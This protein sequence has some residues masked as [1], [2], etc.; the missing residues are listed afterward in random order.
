VSDL[1]EAVRT[2][3]LRYL[4]QVVDVL[5]KGDRAVSLA[6][7][8]LGYNSSA[9]LTVGASVEALVRGVIEANYRFAETTRL[10]IRVDRLDIVEL[11]QDTAITAVYELR[12]APEKLDAL[13]KRTGTL[14][15]CRPDLEYGDGWRPRLFDRGNQ[16]YWPRIIVTDAD[17]QQGDCPPCPGDDAAPVPGADAGSGLRQAPNQRRTALANRLRYLYVGQR[18]RAES[19]VQQRQPGLIETLVRQQIHSAKWQEDFGRMLFQLMVPYDFKD[20]A[21]QLERVVLVVDAYTANLPWELMMGDGAGREEEKRPLSV[22][23]PVVRQLASAKF[24]RDVR[25]SLE[26]TALVIG[27]PSVE[28]FAAAF[29]DPKH[30]QAAV[31]ALP[32]AEKEA[33]AV[34]ALLGA[35]GYTVVT[36]IGEERMATDVLAMLYRQPYRILHIS[37]HGVFDLPHADGLR[38][39]GVVL[40][41]GLLITAAEIQAMEVVPELVFLSCCHLGQIDA[42][43]AERDD[44]TV[45]DG[46]KLAASVARELIEIGVRCVVVAGWAVNDER[47]KLFGEVFYQNLMLQRKPFGDA[48][49]AAREA[50]WKEGQEDITWGAYQAYGDPLWR[51]EPR[52]TGN[53]GGDGNSEFASPEE[54]LDEL[55]R[56]RAQMSRR[57]DRLTDREKN[58]QAKAID[59]LLKK[60]C[61]PGWLT[62]PVLQSALGATWSTLGRFEKARDAYLVAIQAED[63]AG[64]VPIR[65]I[66]QLANIEARLGE[67]SGNAR[68]IDRAVERLHQLDLLV[69]EQA[70]GKAAVAIVNAERCALRGSAHK[71]KASMYANSV[72]KAYRTQV[73]DGKSGPDSDAL[74]AKV[75]MQEA[76]TDAVEAYR[77]GEGVTGD[78]R[79]KPYNALNRLALD[80][81]TPWPPDKGEREASIASAVALAQRCRQAATQDFARSGAFW[82]AIMQPEAILV[83]HLLDGSLGQPGE[84][85]KAALNEVVQ[86]Y[87]E[88]LSNL[89]ATPTELDSVVSQMNLLATFCDA[90][91]VADGEQARTRTA[92]ALLEVVQKIQP[93]ARV[94]DHRSLPE[95]PTV[96]GAPSEL[97]RPVP[98]RRGRSGQPSP[99]K[100]RK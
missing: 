3:V 48:V 71:R 62:L 59:E 24:R 9:N 19:I 25:Q 60:R 100:S 76:L 84:A 12:R 40:S 88:A 64:R 78:A 96:S 4:L 67:Q 98:D 58:A 30:P 36:A 85:G 45:R 91:Y 16:S 37:A 80:A 43:N 13:V 41:D 63:K 54:I 51:A 46:N 65:D 53:G 17:R 83:G 44:R 34:A 38:R 42:T 23:T 97:E 8:L 68:I 21:R 49:H 77:E 33:D 7:V 72:L 95:P 92:D 81:L 57:K 6:S 79:F 39:S 75:N 20:A 93:G 87:T 10:K 52:G 2:G 15:V 47:A 86:A 99:R 29:P 70:A 35:M 82:D 94:P 18:A 14:L 5:G 61:P 28:G 56:A 22:R 66:E 26:R 74:Q 1:T 69:A 11:Y 27:N 50:L 89:T 55:A 32:A 73:N 31:P 90:L